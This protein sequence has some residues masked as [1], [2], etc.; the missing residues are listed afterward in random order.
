MPA[1]RSQRP[2]LLINLSLQVDNEEEKEMCHPYTASGVSCLF[3]ISHDIVGSVSSRLWDQVTFVTDQ[4][5]VSKIWSSY[6]KSTMD[7]M[8]HSDI[9]DQ[10][11]KLAISTGVCGCM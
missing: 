11:P 8:T 2:I 1:L 9:C 3:A 6:R 4:R 10:F 7:G 5:T